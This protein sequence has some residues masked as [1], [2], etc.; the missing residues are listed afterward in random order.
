MPRQ[1]LSRDPSERPTAGPR[2][3]IGPRILYRDFVL[4]RVEVLPRETLDQPKLLGMRKTAVR[5]P[6]VLVETSRVNDQRVPL[7]FCHRTPIIQGI[8]VIAADLAGMSPA[9]EVDDTKIA[10]AAADQHKNALALAIFHELHPIG[11]LELTRATRRLAVQI[12]GV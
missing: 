1:F 9:I 3:R 12:C 8:V 10:V 11:K 6:E 7:P 2:S 4:Q 5:E